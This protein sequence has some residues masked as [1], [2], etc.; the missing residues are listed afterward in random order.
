L[1]GFT[2]VDNAAHVTSLEHCLPYLIFNK[3]ELA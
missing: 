3:E 1:K 2:P